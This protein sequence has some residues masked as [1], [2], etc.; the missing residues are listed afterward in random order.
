M[1]GHNFESLDREILDK[2]LCTSC[3]TCVGI[4]PAKCIEYKNERVECVGTCISCGKCMEVCPGKAF[5]Y[6]DFSKALF[7]KGYNSKD[8]LGSY[9]NIYAG[10][11]NDVDIRNNSGSGGIITEVALYL[12]KNKHVDGVVTIHNKNGSEF[13]FEP[14]IARSEEDIKISAQSKYTL[15]PTNRIISEILANDGKYAFVG[16]PCQ[17]HG[18]RKAMKTNKKL[19]DRVVF[20]IGIFC[21]FNMYAA[22][23]DYLLKKSRIKKSEIKE[24]SYRKKIDGD[25]GFFVTDGVK[26]NYIKK[27][28]YTYLNLFYSPSRCQLCYDYSGEFSDLSV[29]DAWEKG[30]GWSRIICRSQFA[31]NIIQNMRNDN[32]ISLVESSEDEVK[33]SQKKILAHKKRDIWY[34][35]GK[36]KDIPA[37]NIGPKPDDIKPNIK[38]KIQYYIMKFGGTRFGRFLLGLIPFSWLRKVSSRLRK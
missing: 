1:S 29:G 27:H 12:L 2:H 24:L 20:I 16:L 37:I 34:R 32:L 4:C 18:I 6:N 31:E 25:T 8:W 13:E 3:G 36:K 10:H 35:W 30:L 22:S 5:D 9:I 11:S 14:T 23:T 15:V 33:S 21:G 38:G 26:S 7:Q 17:I 19:R 28:E